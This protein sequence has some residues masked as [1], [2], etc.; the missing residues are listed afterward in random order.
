MKIS[1]VLNITG[2]ELLQTPQVQGIEGATVF[3]SKVDRGDLFFAARPEDIPAAVERGAYAIVFDGEPSNAIDD[4]I[5]WIRV[6]SVK[7]AAFRLLRY[8]ILR[9]EVELYLLQP[10]ELSFLKMLSTQRGNLGFLPDSWPKSFE[11]ILNGESSLFVS[12]D[13]ALVETLTPDPRRLEASVEGY[14]ISDT[15]FRSTFKIEGYIYQNKEM[16]PF[17]L[18]YLER[19]IAFAKAHGMPYSL[20]RLHYTRHF[21]PV[22]VDNAL[23]PLPKGKSEKALIFVD[24]V[25]DIVAAREYIRHNGRWLK[26]IVLTPPKTKIEG[27]DRPL[28]YRDPEEARE[29]L[30]QHYFN[31]AFIYGLERDLIRKVREERTLF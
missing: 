20:D 21:F 17:H 16:A 30:R 18:E 14:L 5:A 10:H 4:E 31:Y 6:D 1:D 25:P 3:P 13:A 11:A 9:K 29:L 26:S 24:N 19:V 7:E 28:W 22:F 2:G 8:V 15:L 23:Q 12:D 27:W